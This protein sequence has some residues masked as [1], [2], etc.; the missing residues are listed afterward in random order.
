MMHNKGL[1]KLLEELGELVQIASKKA[2]F[3]D[4]D[5][6]PDGKGSL[7]ARLEDEIADANAAIAFVILKLNLNNNYIDERRNYKL[8]LYKEWDALVD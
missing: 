4:I 1:T 8:N 5:W 6:H 7:K 3:M 2:A